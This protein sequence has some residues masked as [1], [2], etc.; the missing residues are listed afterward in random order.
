MKLV[1]DDGELS[2]TLV[3]A[4]ADVGVVALQRRASLWKELAPMTHFA[5]EDFRR[6]DENEHG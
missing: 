3:A 4:A 5:V 2:A 1:D 6:A